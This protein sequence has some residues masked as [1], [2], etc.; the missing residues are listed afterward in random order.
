[1]MMKSAIVAIAFSV[2]GFSA[3]VAPAM[4]AGNIYDTL[5]ADP[6]FSTLVKIIDATHTRHKTY[7]VTFLQQVRHYLTRGGRS[8]IEWLDDMEREMD[9]IRAAWLWTVDTGEVRTLIPGVQ[10][11]YQYYDIRGRIWEGRALY[12]NLR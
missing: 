10:A 4:A 3:S 5:K 2:L 1:M 9:N 8:D 6:Q 12:G 7:Y 11:L